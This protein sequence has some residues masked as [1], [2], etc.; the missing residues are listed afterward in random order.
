MARML[1]C[2]PGPCPLP[3]L[4][5]LLP[6]VRGILLDEDCKYNSISFSSPLGEN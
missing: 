6:L 3:L 2:R 5:R 4:V 1:G